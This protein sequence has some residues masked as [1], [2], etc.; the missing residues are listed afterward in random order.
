MHLARYTVMW[1]DSNSGC[2][3]KQTVWK[4]AGDQKSFIVIY[5][6]K[7]IP[8]SSICKGLIVQV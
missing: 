6:Y 5:S 3:E 7:N 1:M 8:N 2:V 4:N